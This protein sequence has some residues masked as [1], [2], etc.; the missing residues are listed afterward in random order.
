MAQP[1]LLRRAAAVAGA[2]VVAIISQHYRLEYP[3]NL[4]RFTRYPFALCFSKS[5]SEAPLDVIRF[6]NG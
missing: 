3:L 4:N 1:R 2:R 6:R 5:F